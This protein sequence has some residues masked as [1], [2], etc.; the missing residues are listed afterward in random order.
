M[1]L[2]CAI[3]PIADMTKTNAEIRTAAGCVDRV[4]PVS[5][6][7]APP[8]QQQPDETPTGFAQGDP[9]PEEDFNDNTVDYCNIKGLRIILS[10]DLCSDD[11]ILLADEEGKPIA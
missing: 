2:A 11:Y 5:G 6:M 8:Q 1:D 4:N 10:G 7:S 3:K 9:L